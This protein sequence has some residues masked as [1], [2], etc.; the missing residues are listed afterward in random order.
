MDFYLWEALALPFHEIVPQDAEEAVI[1][2][3]EGIL[4]NMSPPTQSKSS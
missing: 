1:I 3:D 4:I 2:A